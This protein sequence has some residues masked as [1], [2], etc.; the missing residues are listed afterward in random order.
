MTSD[1]SSTDEDVTLHCP[2]CAEENFKLI[3]MAGKAGE[4]FVR[5]QC[6]NCSEH[7]FFQI[8]ELPQNINSLE[9]IP[10]SR[11][12]EQINN[13]QQEWREWLQW[14]QRHLDKSAATK[15]TL[16][17]A[18]HWLIALL[19]FAGTIFFVLDRWHLLEPFLENTDT[20]QQQVMKYAEGLLAIPC[21]PSNMK[22]IIRT[23]PI[24]YTRERPVHKNWIQYGE[25]GVYWGEE[26][27]KIHR[28]NFWF[29]GWPKVTQL[30]STLVHEL[31]H[32]ASP[33]LGHNLK[34]YE[35]LERDTKCVLEY[36]N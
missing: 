36:L 24:R 23:V 31:R 4:R 2:S 22:V 10:E 32:R 7:L 11:K 16:S 35:L 34:F 12:F 21:F 20:R 15:P 18:A 5:I 13:L 14:K 6:Q 25:A 29:F 30:L 17:K 8:P 27:I 28:S 33:D 19:L 1:V 3:P 9:K 26:Q